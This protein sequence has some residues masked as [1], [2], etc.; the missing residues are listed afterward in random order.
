MIPKLSFVKPSMHALF[1]MMMM[2]MVV[3]VVVVKEEMIYVQ[4]GG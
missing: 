3:V 1:G 2:I 4:M